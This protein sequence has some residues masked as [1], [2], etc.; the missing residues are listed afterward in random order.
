MSVSVVAS[1]RFEP[2]NLSRAESGEEGLAL[3]INHEGR[4]KQFVQRVVMDM[5]RPL[6]ARS[7]RPLGRR[8]AK[9]QERP[10]FRGSQVDCRGKRVKHNGSRY[11]AGLFAGPAPTSTGL[12]I[13]NSANS[14]HPALVNA[15]GSRSV[16]SP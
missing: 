5:E 10:R 15:H 6:T 13:F 14:P 9:S 8:V 1:P 4:L 16:T 2:A 3:H 7:G 11:S 12:T